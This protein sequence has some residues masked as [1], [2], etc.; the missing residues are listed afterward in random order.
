MKLQKNRIVITGCNGY[1]GQ[2]LAE[3]LKSKGYQVN[4][5]VRKKN[6]LL[7]VHQFIWDPSKGFIESD[8]FQE[9]DILIHL[10]GA[11]IS[12][13]LWSTK[14]KKELWESRV[15]SLQLIDTH[16]Q[17]KGIS[18]AKV[19]SASGINIFPFT[20]KVFSEDDVAGR[21][22][23]GQLCEAWEKAAIQFKSSHDYSIVRTPIV[24]GKKAP[25]VETVQKS[26]I[27]SY[28]VI[29]GDG[30]QNIEWISIQ[31]I[32]S[33]YLLAIQ[34]ETKVF[35]AVNPLSVNYNEVVQVISN[36]KKLI[37]LPKFVLAPLGEFGELITN[38]VH[39]QNNHLL[40]VG[41]LSLQE[42]LL[43]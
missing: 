1:I 19:I 34:S 21:H 38:G 18:L 25:F 3:F 36:G 17:K 6:Q 43:I 12:G 8:A 10:A 27:N 9:N 32:L 11:S 2:F 7:S 5:L 16:L 15:N 30:K 37:H 31:D 41:Y 29:I 22:F 23:L 42:S 4:A 20:T 28:A 40:K 14:R 35:H 39:V 33:Y 24:I 13:G 26:I